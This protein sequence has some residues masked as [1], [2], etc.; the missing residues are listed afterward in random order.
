MFRNTL[1]IALVLSAELTCAQ[2][3]SAPQSIQSIGAGPF[4]FPISGTFSIS[5]EGGASVFSSPTGGREIR[6]AF[7]RNPTAPKT[8]EQK[9]KTQEKVRG[10]WERFAAEQ[11]MEIVRPFKRWDVPPNLAVFGMASQFK[12]S[13]STRHYVQYAVTDGPQMGFF[14]VEGTGPAE[15]VA[16]ELESLVLKVTIADVSNSPL[17]K[18]AEQAARP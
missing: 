6:V 12:Q 7:L 17:Q 8:P 1:L 3:L 13:G 9:T 14:I 16:A 4:E 5:L 15:S 10:N 11:K 2:P 18:D